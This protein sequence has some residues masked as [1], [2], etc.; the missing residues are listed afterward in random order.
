[1][2]AVARRYARAAV[3]AAAEKGKDE[4]DSLLDGLIAFRDSYKESAELRELLANPSL[5]GERDAALLA[6][7]KKLGLSELSVS[8]VRLLVE[9][10]RLELIGEVTEQVDQLSDDLAGRMH[11][12][13]VSAIPL[14]DPQKKRIEK[15]LERR[16]ERPVDATIEIDPEILGGLVVR[17]G[18]LTIDSSVR[19]QL[20]LVRQQ[21]LGS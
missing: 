17:I 15:A 10:E 21:L 20:E 16:F 6:F 2:S 13:V 7:A 4:V 12:S 19:R 18:D 3:D 11:A 9:N 5:A 8:L 1:M 14:S